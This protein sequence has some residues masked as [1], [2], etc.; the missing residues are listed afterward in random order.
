MDLNGLLTVIGLIIAAYAILSRER[1]LTLLLHLGIFEITLICTATIAVHYFQFYDYFKKLGLA[2]EMKSVASE[3][4]SY[5]IIISTI[6]VLI[7]KARYGK[8]S[9]LRVSRFQELVE[10]L[11][12]SD[13]HAVLIELLYKN[14][15]YLIRIIKNDSLMQRAK[16]WSARADYDPVSLAAYISNLEGGKLS[17]LPGYNKFGYRKIKACFRWFAY[18]IPNN[19][20]KITIAKNIFRTTL[21]NEKFVDSIIKV[22]PYFGIK[23]FKLD[24]FEFSEFI[25]IYFRKMFEKTDSILYFEIKN[26]QYL[27]HGHRY[28]ISAHNK[29]LCALF[30]DC[31]VAEE[32]NIWK[33]LGDGVIAYL[34]H[35]RLN[36]DNDVYNHELGDFN[37]TALNSPL[38]A[39]ISFFDIMV[40]ESIFQN[41]QWHMWLYYFPT[42]TE[43]ICNNF[44]PKVSRDRLQYEFPTKYSLVLYRIISTHCDWINTIH[45]LPSNQENIQL[46]STDCSGENGNLIK[47]SILSLSN[48]LHL[49]SEVENIPENLKSSI[50][51]RV[52]SQYFDLRKSDKEHIRRYAD[53]FLNSLLMAGFEYMHENLAS[54]RHNLLYFLNKRDNIHDSRYVDDLKKAI[55]EG[56]I[57]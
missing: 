33:P 4:V 43:K 44:A 30:S 29:I 42:F 24:L 35:L 17:E 25:D 32:L 34:D 39:G 31:H 10:E 3:D 21:L 16:K 55:V 14:F 40:T 28:H 7:I 50:F 11:N 37:E 36:K 22:R 26:N 23:T 8:I 45:D 13:S 27:N 6:S 1:R 18:I 5:I 56:K 49:I 46:V 2:I 52:F 9:S 38:M 20:S 51:S 48:C 57:S 12:N 47:S 15:D 54:Y 19:E 41:I 53:A